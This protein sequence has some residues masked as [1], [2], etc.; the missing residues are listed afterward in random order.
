MLL[1]LGVFLGAEV[2]RKRRK[3]GK[4]RGER[5]LFLSLSAHTPML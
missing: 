4:Q 5:S 2:R 1:G 3:K